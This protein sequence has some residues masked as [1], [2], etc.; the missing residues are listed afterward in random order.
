MA[1]VRCHPASSEPTQILVEI[2]ELG[3]QHQWQHAEGLGGPAQ[4]IDTVSS[5][6]V[7]IGSNLEAPAYRRQTEGG[8]MV[9]GERCC[10]RH[11]G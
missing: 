7:G 5:R 1:Q 8:E 9:C 3:T 10:H 4:S 11:A 6:R 2:A